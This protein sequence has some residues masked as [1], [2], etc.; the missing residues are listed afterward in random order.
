MA[1]TTREKIQKITVTTAF[2]PLVL[3]DNWNKVEINLITLCKDIYSTDYKS[4]QRIVL[5]PN[6]RFRR[7]YLHDH[8][9]QN[10][11]DVISELYQALTD[12]N[13][14]KNKKK[15]IKDKSCQTQSI[16]I[17]SKPKIKLKKLKK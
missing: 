10:N 12:L 11:N 2:I 4:F 13:S 15:S 8:H 14:L 7:I 16:I 1:N 5:H 6:F 17:N 9:Y 3:A